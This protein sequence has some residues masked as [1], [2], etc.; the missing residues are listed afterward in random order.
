M[1]PRAVGAEEMDHS[2]GSQSGSKSWQPCGINYMLLP[3]KVFNFFYFGAVGSIIPFLTV[4]LKHLGL[5]A[6]ETGIITGCAVLLAALIRPL[7]GLLADAARARRVLLLLCCLLFGAAF[8]SLWFLPQRKVNTTM[9]KWICTHTQS[10]STTC[11]RIPDKQCL[12]QV[13]DTGMLYNADLSFHYCEQN[14][15]FTTLGLKRDS[16]D[17]H[18]FCTKEQYQTLCKTTE[19]GL[20]ATEQQQTSSKWGQEGLETLTMSQN[21][22]LASKHVQ[23]EPPEQ[24]K[25]VLDLFPM[26]GDR[27]FM[28]LRDRSRDLDIRYLARVGLQISCGPIQD[29]HGDGGSTSTDEATMAD[30]QPGRL[31]TNTQHTPFNNEESEKGGKEHIL[32]LTPSTSVEDGDEVTNGVVTEDTRTKLSELADLLHASVE[33]ENCEGQA[34]GVAPNESTQLPGTRGTSGVATSI[35]KCHCHVF[36]CQACQLTRDD[37][38]ALTFDRVF[39]LTLL[40][41]AVARAFYS[42]SSSLL[43]AVTYTMLDLNRHHWGRQRMWGTIGTAAA[44]T[45]IM[46]ANVTATGDS[47]GALFLTGFC[48][49]IC[50]CLTGYFLKR[51]AVAAKRSKGFGNLRA[52]LRK[53]SFLVFLGK[54]LLFGILCGSV[55][56]FFFWFLRELGGG[57]TVLG[58]CLLANCASSVV[59]LRGAAVLLRRVGEMRTMYL[60]LPVYATRFIVMSL[61]EEPWVAVPVELLHGLT[62]SLL[63]A[64]CSANIHLLAPPGTQATCQGIAGAI[65]WDLDW[66]WPLIRSKAEEAETQTGQDVKLM[67]HLSPE[68]PENNHLLMTQLPSRCDRDLPKGDNCMVMQ[69]YATIDE[70]Q[71]DDEDESR[72]DRQEVTGRK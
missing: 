22:T 15:N 18:R 21:R 36:V 65:Y 29:D 10:N 13:E 27:V 16:L 72:S 43:D 35:G 8:A 48:L 58:A 47:F 19:V 66:R 28:K 14:G 68:V 7:L 38:P 59:V 61:L 69:T 37:S 49:I 4:Y 30:L 17:E 63:W 40:L 54:I 52:V 64:A 67:S 6:P 3:L 44:A 11:S 70:L 23:E 45:V 42:S 1:S 53:V 51:Q 25:L 62:Y 41:M 60:V 55:Q 20:R 24:A 56:N 71:S 12:A 34:P 57:Q 26:V 39:G 31:S 2:A 46:G 5:T 33:T 50:T 9:P 32:D